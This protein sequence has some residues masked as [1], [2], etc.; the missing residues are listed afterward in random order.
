MNKSTASP[1][2]C[3]SFCQAT[4]G[5]RLWKTTSAAGGSTCYLKGAGPTSPVACPDCVTGSP[6]A[7]P[8]AYA[9]CG[10]AAC[11]ASAAAAGLSPVGAAPMCWASAAASP[12]D[13]PCVIALPAIGRSD[14]AFGDQTYWRGRAWAPQAFLTWLGLKRYEDVPSAAAARAVL[15]EKAQRLF[16]RQLSLFGQVNENLDGLTG[17]GSD[18]SRADSY[19]HWGALNAFVGLIELGIFPAEVLVTPAPARA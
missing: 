8:P 15:V 19:Y 16:L 2:D 6:A 12:S 7:A 14:P 4:P 11:N 1:A 10:T 18:S 13:W 5:C 9:T 3:C 17:L